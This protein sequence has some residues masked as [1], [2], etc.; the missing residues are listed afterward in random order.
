[1][2]M[3]FFF[4]VLNLKQDWMKMEDYGKRTIQFLCFLFCL[5]GQGTQDLPLLTTAVQCCEQGWINNLVCGLKWCQNKSVCRAAT[6][7]PQQLIGTF[8][9]PMDPNIKLM[10]DFS[11]VS[12][13]Y[14][15]SSR[16]SSFNMSPEA[17]DL[18]F[19]SEDR[20]TRRL[21]CCPQD[22]P[23]HAWVSAELVGASGWCD[24]YS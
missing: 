5:T 2:V 3:T 9:T 14:W 17:D 15:T 7:Q 12:L 13:R 1:M 6:A 21:Y 8:L 11:A 4:S 10:H 19:A 23:L 18:Y 24:C 22:S 20:N 16:F